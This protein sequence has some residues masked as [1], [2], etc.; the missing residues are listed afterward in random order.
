MF[1]NIT[2][3]PKPVF[4]VDFFNQN[5]GPIFVQ[6]F[7]VLTP[8]LQFLVR[9]FFF[10]F[11]VESE[12]GNVT[13]IVLRKRFVHMSE[14]ELLEFLEHMKHSISFAG[15]NEEDILNYNPP[16]S[17]VL[18]QNRIAQ[19]CRNCMDEYLEYIKQTTSRKL[20]GWKYIKKLFLLVNGNFWVM[21]YLEVETD[22]H[23]DFTPL[24][25]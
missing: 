3:S 4:W 2:N 10:Q 7:F 12:F 24:H 1:Q 16:H 18:S 25:I 8:E 22:V 11:L 17:Y 6:E 9:K 14:T 19:I 20:N 21:R 5:L 23:S 13:V 15:L